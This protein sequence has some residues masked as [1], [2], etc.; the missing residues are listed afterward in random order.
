VTDL[1]TSPETT[2]STSS[3]FVYAHVPATE[4]TVLLGVYNIRADLQTA[5][6]TAA[7]MTP[8]SSGTTGTGFAG[9]LTWADKVVTA[10]SGTYY[11]DGARST[12]L[13]Y[14]YWYVLMNTWSVRGDLQTAFSNAYYYQSS[15]QGLVTWAGLVVTGAPGYG[16]DSART[17]LQPSP[18]WYTLMGIYFT[19]PD[20]QTAFPNALT[21][22]TSFQNLVTW[23]GWVVTSQPG[24]G[25][26]GAKSA[27]T[28]YGYWY[29][30]MGI[31]F[32]RP[33]LQTAFPNAYTS[34][35]NWQQLVDWADAVVTNVPGYGVD[36]AHA[37]L[38][39]F[40]SYYVANGTPL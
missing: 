29:D 1:A 33:D 12:L 36:G 38:D 25:A 40:G 2:T 37:Q 15:Y 24:Y 21:M 28:T 30:L 3:S 14:A 18:Y 35:A 26:D 17:L 32:T 5:F 10:T 4:L 9:L 7:A 8:S 13:P 39:V 27:L 6:G 20:L 22:T 23:S 34:A 16:T 31:Y 11:T 19:R